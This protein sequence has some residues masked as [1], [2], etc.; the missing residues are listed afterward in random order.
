MR[1]ALFVL[2]GLLAG[3]ADDARPAASKADA[4]DAGA[5]RSDAPWAGFLDVAPRTVKVHGKS[6]SLAATARLFANFRP[7]DGDAK[8][9]PTFVLFNG[10][11]A[12]VV[13]AFGTGPTTVDANGDIV[14]N[15][16]SFTSMGNLLYVDPRQSG[17]SYDVL[18]DRAP[19]AADCS[20]DVFDEYVDAADVLFAVTTFFDAHP[21]L[22][23]P[24]VWVGESYAG[25]RIQWMTAFARG[26]FDLAPY[27]D[28]ALE[29]RLSSFGR[30]TDLAKTQILLEPWLLGKAHADA[31]AAACADP[32]LAAAVSAS[33][34][35][36]CTNACTCAA[37][38]DRSLYDYART[39][40]DLDAQL[41]AADEA[42][43][44]P[45]K[46]EKLLGVPLSAIEGLQLDQ[47]ER[48]FKCNAADSTTPNEQA[49]EAALGTLPAGQ[50]WFLPFT[51]LTPGKGD[52]APADWQTANAVGAAFVDNL[53][54]VKTFVTD[55]PLDLVVPERAL[56]PGL[57]AIDGVTNVSESP[58]AITITDASGTASL[59]L[60]HYPAAGHMITMAAPADLA[61]DVRAWL[62]L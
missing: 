3:C 60:F 40:A 54:H 10:F 6:N 17:F 16:A 9:A 46:A 51:P 21:D 15:P 33:T 36:S 38:A 20:S 2:L 49:I 52:G 41:L 13:R 43:V 8:T 23:G 4:G 57:R 22:T 42:Q 56:A 58:G 61:R 5:L 39:N 32:A 45:S 50:S 55:G 48:G 7:A 29:A 11:A 18:A 31:I 19:A 34:G 12:D 1:A 37:A 14:A 35:A 25:V 59:A 62:G 26:R 28:D 30:R 53:M 47:R 27:E 24:I 44:D